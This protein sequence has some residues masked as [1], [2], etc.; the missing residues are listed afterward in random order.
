MT[1]IAALVD[2]AVAQVRALPV[3]A[4][5][6]MR[7]VRVALSRQLKS[8]EPDEVIDAAMRLKTKGLDWFGWE[9]IYAHKP[10]LKSIDRDTVEALGQG[11]SSWPETDGFGMILAGPA[12]LHGR[13]NDRDI[14]RWAKSDDLWWRRAAL[15]ATTGLNNKS[16]GGRGDAERTLEIVEL[17]IDDRED[18][19]VKAVSWALRMLAPWQPKAVEDFLET[20]GDRLAPRVRREVRNKLRTG[21]KNPKSGPTPRHALPSRPTS[22]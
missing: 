21:H 22:L 18:M 7:A 5:A 3:K 12:W 6:P 19:I 2:A 4:A 20:H 1:A 17:L 14:A 16:R 9:L 10:T 11:M 8:A 15:V 13:L